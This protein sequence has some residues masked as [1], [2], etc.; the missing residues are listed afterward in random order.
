M[1]D[2]KLLW[3]LQDLEVGWGMMGIGRRLKRE[4]ICVPMAD[5]SF[6]MAESTQYCKATILQLFFVF[7]LINKIDLSWKQSPHLDVLVSSSVACD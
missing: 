4:G 6:C 3:S 7:F 1:A 2:G 5:S